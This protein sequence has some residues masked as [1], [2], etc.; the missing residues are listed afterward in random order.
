[1][2]STI[3]YDDV[4]VAKWLRSSDVPD[5]LRTFQKVIETIP[6]DWGRF[7]LMQEIAYELFQRTGEH[8]KDLIHWKLAESI[9]YSRLVKQFDEMMRSYA[10]TIEK[11]V[12]RVFMILKVA[13][14]GKEYGL[15]VVDQLTC[16]SRNEAS[17][18]ITTALERI[19]RASFTGAIT[20]ETQTGTGSEHPRFIPQ[21]AGNHQSQGKKQKHKNR[22]QQG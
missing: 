18:R 6:E 4:S 12:D 13:I 9:V 7:K 21:P 22:P 3:L 2:T 16:M 17:A 10:Q 19:L 5:I 20:E 14:C 8:G 1:M 15:S 11:P